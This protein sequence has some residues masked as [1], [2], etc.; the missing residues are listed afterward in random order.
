MDNERSREEEWGDLME[1]YNNFFYAD[2]G[3]FIASLMDNELEKYNWD[4]DRIRDLIKELK[5][6]EAKYGEL[7]EKEKK[8][9]LEHKETLMDMQT[10]TNGISEYYRKMSNI[11]DFIEDYS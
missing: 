9:I 10:P 11:Y 3:L 8:E 7:N 5:E 2:D 1:E 4:F 6:F